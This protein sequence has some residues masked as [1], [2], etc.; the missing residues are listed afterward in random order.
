MMRFRI[1][2]FLALALIP[3][4][5]AGNCSVTLTDNNALVSY[6]IVPE[7]TGAVCTSL[8]LKDNSYVSQVSMTQQGSYYNKTYL[9][10]DY[11][12]TYTSYIVCNLTGTLYS[13]ECNFY[14]T[15]QIGSS[16]QG[17]MQ[18]LT[19]KLYYPYY[20]DVNKSEEIRFYTNTTGTA[21]NITFEGTEYEMTNGGAYFYIDI[22]NPDPENVDFNV[23]LNG[24]LSAEGTMRFR[25]PFY[26]TIKLWNSATNS[27]SVKQY[28]NDFQY[29]F[30]T[31]SND[32]LGGSW[33]DADADWLQF[34]WLDRLLFG[35]AGLRYDTTVDGRLAFWSNYNNGMGRIKLY[36]IGN[37]TLNLETTKTKSSLGWDYEFVFPQDTESKYY[38]GITV[39]EIAYPVNQVVDVFVDKWEFMQFQVM[40]NWLWY[41]FLFAVWLG[42]TIATAMLSQD[43]R[44][45][46]IVSVVLLIVCLALAV[47]V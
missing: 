18:N 12:Y 38:H 42:G 47:I 7:G 33:L 35:T 45:T 21:A 2:F 43:F 4:V 1:I 6:L 13:S 25:I 10:L 11:G 5:Y 41:G 36:E 46:L 14:V 26:V 27:S 8:L 3:I 19:G 17:T 22:S 30:L 15:S 28:K 40:M 29:I 9:A 44:S 34:K 16:S 23:T 37:Y 39:L 24:T 31:T 20:M 32:R